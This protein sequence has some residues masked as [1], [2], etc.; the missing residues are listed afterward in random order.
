MGRIHGWSLENDPEGVCKAVL[1]IFPIAINKMTDKSKL[2]KG[3]FILAYTL[4][5]ESIMVKKL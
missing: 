2:K 4:K 5:G 3:K 1:D